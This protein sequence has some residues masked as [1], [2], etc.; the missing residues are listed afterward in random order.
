[1]NYQEVIR[2]IKSGNLKP[3]YLL[4][5]AESYFIDEIIAAVEQILTADEKAFNQ[6]TVY[7]KDTDVI[8]LINM[9][10]RFPMMAS[11][12][13]I[14]VKEAQYLKRIEELKH[15]AKNVVPTTIL[16]LSHKE[17]T[18]DKRKAFVKDIAKAGLIFES[19]PLYDN[20]VPSVIKRLVEEKQKQI[21]L[22]STYLLQEFI[23]NDLS[24]LIHEIDK[25]LITL[26]VSEN[27][28]TP[29]HIEKNIGY[30]KDYNVFELQKA[31]SKRDILKT[32][33]IIN[34]FISNPKHSINEVIP[35]LF[36]YFQKI[37]KYHYLKDKSK[38]N[39]ASVLK[40]NPFFVK[41]YADGARNFP[42]RKVVEII[43]ILGAYD[44]KSKGIN[45][46]DANA[47][48]LLKE[49]VFKILH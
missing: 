6:T 24:K 26:P 48:L 49:M 5:G 12:Q 2:D 43:E 21:D 32:N 39:V 38:N 20:E 10:K 42:I 23:G 25:L 11:H 15:Y 33:R 29:E 36:P 44:L 41:D 35:S 45:F 22:K 31:I 9:C 16:V 34:Y 46:S 1:M 17:K 47:D 13:V 18:V 27:V 19:K 30:S 8:E 4:H 37:L 7:G 14:I 28:I 40:V 3:I